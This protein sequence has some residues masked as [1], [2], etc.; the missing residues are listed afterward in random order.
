LAQIIKEAGHMCVVDTRYR[1]EVKELL[2]DFMDE[3]LAKHAQGTITAYHLV[4]VVCVCACV[5]VCVENTQLTRCPSIPP[6]EEDDQGDGD[7]MHQHHD[8]N[9]KKEKEK[10]KQEEENGES[11]DPADI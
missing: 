2:V 9:E 8:T 11:E 3:V 1:D 4:R 7:R 6:L 10:E 5:C